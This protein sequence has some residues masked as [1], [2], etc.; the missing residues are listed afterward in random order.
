MTKN[1]LT[2]KNNEC[3]I[4]SNAIEISD[5]ATATTQKPI[6]VQINKRASDIKCIKNLFRKVKQ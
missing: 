2:T 1:E 5:D 3:C 6:K 4:Y